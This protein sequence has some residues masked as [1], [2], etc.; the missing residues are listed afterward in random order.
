MR[1]R[2][3]ASLAWASLQDLFDQGTAFG[4]LALVHVVM[5]AGDTLVT[6][7]LAGSLFFSVSPT[8]AKSKVLAYLLLTIAPFAVVSPVLGPLIDRSA[9]GRRVLVALSASAR[10]LLCWSMS[11]HLNSLW[12]FPEAFAVL[13]SSKL[14]GVTRGALV[15][16]MARTDQFREHATGVGQ[17]GW[18]SEGVKQHRGF[19]GFNAQLTLLGTLSGLIAGS[20]GAALLKTVG[21]TSVL[22]FAAAVFAAGTVA[23]LRLQR[24]VKVVRDEVAM[25]PE[26]RDLHA[27]I[28]LGVGEVTWSLSASALMRF[29][30]GFGTFLLAFGLRRDHAGLQ[31]FAFALSASAL[32]SLLGLGLV[33][34]VRN[35]LAES[36]L[37]ALAVLS[38][39]IGAGV[40]SRHPT[41]VAQTVLAGWLGLCAAVAQPS[42][43]AITQR[44]VPTGAQGRTF[45]RFAVRQ[46]LAWVVGALIPV[47]ISLNFGAGDQFLA[48]VM[49]VGG[50][51]YSVGRKVSHHG[52]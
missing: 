21:A 51:I 10:V 50:V 52:I 12:L 2:G 3:L 1:R 29:G 25:S 36:S 14:Y 8:E 46:Q 44:L 49:V 37:L 18:P 17:S 42:F 35:A 13:V 41:L 28:P 20:L 24:P 5:M 32:G 34:R 47:A 9:N 45:A 33:T 40:A 26:E 19:A 4:R 39:G 16:E 11:Q 27:L 6:V 15:P 38:T 22:V 7:S 30:V 23:S 48:L 31:W 43:D